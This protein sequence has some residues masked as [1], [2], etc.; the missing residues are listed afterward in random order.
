MAGQFLIVP[1][2][3]TYVVVDERSISSERRQRKPSHTHG[4]MPDHPRMYPA[5]VLSG[6]GIRKGERIGSV[7]NHDVA[8]TI[9][10]LLGIQ[11][12]GVEGRVLNE[13]FSK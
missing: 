13:V 10:R 3:D 5:L 7:R 11:M 8:P 2:I 6:Y 9:A 4:Y 12:P 1:E